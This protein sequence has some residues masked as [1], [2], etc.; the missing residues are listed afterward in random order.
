[1]TRTTTVGGAV[2]RYLGERGRRGDF[3]PETQR[4][5][6][7]ILRRFADAAGPD[8]SI[9]QLTRVQVR[10]W[11]GDLKVGRSTARNH[12]STVKTF[13]RWCVENDLLRADPTRGMRPPR[14]PRRLPRTLDRAAAAR[15]IDALPDA[16]A[17]L[18]VY[19]MLHMGLRCGEVAR[20]QIGDVDFAQ[21]LLFI[22]GKAQNERLLPIPGEAW[23]ALT[24]YL[25]DEPVGS[26][27][28]VRNYREPGRP[29]TPHYVSKLVRSWMAA[30]GI[31]DAP[32]DGVSAHALR[33]T[34]ASDLLDNGAHIRQVQQVLDHRS[35][36]TT[37][38][39]LRRRDAIDLREVVDGR[40][41]RAVPAV[42][43]A[44]D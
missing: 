28:L 3:A 8:L 10:R 32:L 25:A 13:L 42:P 38:R 34:C 4:H 18:I 16:R 30:A 19:W 6:A 41:Y 36:S 27:P 11:W 40:S 17:R 33:R 9:A 12:L 20:L 2:K 23:S 44:A 35:I 5:V 37:E 29:L 24:A 7:S 21:R 14:E 22:R 31:K 43:A 15:L 1:M 26:G 39:Y